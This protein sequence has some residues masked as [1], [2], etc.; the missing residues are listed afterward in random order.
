MRQLLVDLDNLGIFGINLL[1]FC[2]PFRNPEIYMQKGYR[3][4][5]PPYQTPYNYWYAGGLPIAGSER[6]CL[7]LVAFALERGLDLGVHYC[8]LENKHTGQVYQQNH[9]RRLSPRH[10]FS[11]QDFFIKSA[12]V[13]GE[14]RGTVLKFFKDEGIDSYLVDT[15]LDLLEFHVS[16]IPKLSGLDVSVAICSHV[17]EHRPEGD[18]LRELKVE[19]IEPEQFDR[20][21]DGL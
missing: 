7:E 19:R 17:W 2:F 5:N 9:G 13:F 6:D 10:H 1:E 20:V 18:V 21:L 11:E 3:I 16:Q 14:D 8:S 12:K 15:D 4:K